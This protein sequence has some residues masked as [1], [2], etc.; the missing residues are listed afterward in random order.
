MSEDGKNMGKAAEE[1]RLLALDD[2]GGTEDKESGQTGGA[3]EGRGVGVEEEV[4][5]LK[6]K[7]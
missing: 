4:V 6:P 2:G 5:M 1:L 7:G 3:G